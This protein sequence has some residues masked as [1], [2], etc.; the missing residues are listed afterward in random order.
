M[1]GSKMRAFEDFMIDIEQELHG[2]A[3]EQG[4]ELSSAEMESIMYH[5]FENGEDYSFLSIEVCAERLFDEY[6][7]DRLQL[8]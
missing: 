5:L 3:E 2:I 6:I 4:E 7:Q 8:V 1:G